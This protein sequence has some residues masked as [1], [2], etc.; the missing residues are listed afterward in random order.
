MRK[1]LIPQT[2]S[3]Y[4]A[5][6]HSHTSCSDGRLTPQEMKEEYKKRGYSILAFSDHDYLRT[7]NELTDEEFLIITAYE[8]SIRSDDDVTPHVFRKVVDMN[9]YAKNP[10]EVMHIGFH[11]NSIEW[12]IK[13]GK[14]TK[15][16]AKSVKY[17]GEYRDLHYYPANINKIIRSANE[18]GYLVAINHTNWALTNYAD[19]GAYEGAWAFEVYNHGCYALAGLP[20]CEAAYED[21]LRSGKHVFAIATDDNHN[22]YELESY[23]CDS[24]GGFTMIKAEK[25]DYES[26]I[27]AMEK[28]NFYASTGPEIHELYYEDGKIHIKCS[29]VADIAML[30]MGR[31]G[32]RIADSNG[33]LIECASF[34][35]DCEKELY[36]YIRF[37]IT[38][39]KGRKAWTN[40]YYVDEIDSTVPIRR[41]IWDK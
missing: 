3:F 28:G 19:Y 6:L 30:T 31:K 16:E 33:S 34:D 22:T 32:H 4:K 21:I 26:I 23:R 39:D 5:N 7:H 37:R 18:H 11:P 38:D 36:G 10:N 27:E 29:P 20:D 14:I 8:T 24:F 17:Q 35:I 41:T 1:Y 2:G 13:E 25:L 15:E 40:P 9:F 12:W